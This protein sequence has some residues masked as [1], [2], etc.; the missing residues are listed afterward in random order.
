MQYVV[1]IPRASKHGGTPDIKLL[2]IN[3]KSSLVKQKPWTQFLQIK[4]KE[5]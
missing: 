2:S 4:F 5:Q 3:V 1:N